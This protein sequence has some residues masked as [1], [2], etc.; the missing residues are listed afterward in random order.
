MRRHSG[1][2]KTVL[3]LTMAAAL[4]AVSAC[5]KDANTSSGTGSPTSVEVMS[6]W[7]GPGEEPG[8]NA[9]VALLKT[10]HPEITFRLSRVE[11]DATGALK[12][13]GILRIAGVERETALTLATQRSDAGITVTGQVPLMMTDFGIEPPKA[14]LGMLKTDPKLTVTFEIV[15][16]LK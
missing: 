11:A 6:W 15:L 3:A 7:V 13:I 8:L 16:G 1:V 12:G 9:M 5:S 2:G 14:M 4:A 10:Q